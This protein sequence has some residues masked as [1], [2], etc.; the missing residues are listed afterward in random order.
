MGNAAKSLHP[1]RDIFEEFV[2]NASF[3]WVLRTRQLT[4]PHVF[5]DAIAEL[6]SRIQSNLD[7]IFVCVADAW[8]I[9]VEAAGDFAQGGEA[10]V[11][12]ATAFRTEDVAKIQLATDFGLTNE[13][14]FEGLISALAW[15]PGPLIHPWLKQ[16]FSSKNL[17]HKAIAMA[18][19]RLRR[20]D[21]A[22]YLN[23]ILQR[24]DCRAHLPLYTQCLRLIGELKRGDLA[25]EL[26]KGVVSE[27]PDVKFWSLWS[28]M[29]LGQRAQA[30]LF[31]PYIFADNPLREKALAM[32]FRVLPLATARA[33]IGELSQEE[34]TTRL[35]IKACG[36]LGDPSA[37]DWLISQMA[38]A[39]LARAAGEA[40]YLITGV[41]LVEAKLAAAAPEEFIAWEKALDDAPPELA[42][43]DNL[44]WPNANTINQHWQT[45]RTQFQPAQLYFLGLLQ[46]AEFPLGQRY[47]RQR[48]LIKALA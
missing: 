32:A 43:D 38:H 6:D 31:K 2:D 48:D 4:Q 39:Q 5:Q 26:V 35:A 24:D 46:P 12:A 7:G 1:Y 17:D 45:L 13:Q 14:T 29:L 25:A 42:E 28:S 40:F 18:T 3:F 44:P 36:V 33:W 47:C 41:N 9:I 30:E 27:D 22:L 20:E 34:S 19:C 11:L 15:L 8:E 37:V 23:Q 16:F 10:F 21:P